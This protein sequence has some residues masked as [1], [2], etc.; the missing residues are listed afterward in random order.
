LAPLGVL[1]GPIQVENQLSKFQCDQK[2]IE[3][4]KHA[5]QFKEMRW[6]NT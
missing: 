4:A 3:A 6:C 1:N 2:H 5:Y